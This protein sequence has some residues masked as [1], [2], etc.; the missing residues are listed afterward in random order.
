M[1]PTQRGCLVAEFRLETDRLVLRDWRE[2]DLAPF[3]KMSAD[4]AVMA[5]L[6]P[7]MTSMQATA[8]IEEL[9]TVRKNLGHTFWALERLEDRQFLGWCGLIR[10]DVEV[11]SGQLEIGWR[12]ASDS[13]GKGYARE[14][15]QASLDWAFAT[16]SDDRVW[17]I[18]S[19]GNSRSWGL[20]ERLGMMRHPELDFDHPDVAD[21]S[22]L[23]PH[24]TYSI[25][26][27]KG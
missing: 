20:M 23:K 27:S 24:V 2:F 9:M 11:I 17:A 25:A 16:L 12:L 13:W 4:P 6:G 15:A 22:P 14:A 10:G 8:L 19:A 18:T 26:K 7:V 5:T 1:L 3:A 21:G